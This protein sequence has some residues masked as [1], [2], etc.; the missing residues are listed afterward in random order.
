MLIALQN[1]ATL[2]EASRSLSK[3]ET[4][5]CP[6][7]KSPVH[8]KVGAVMRPHFAH[9]QNRACQVFS[10]GET[11]EHIQGKMHLKEWLESQDI[12]VELEAYLPEL[13]QRPDLLVTYHGQ[14]I[15]IEFQCSSLSIHKVTERTAGYLKN[16]YRVIWILGE[17]FTYKNQL[18]AFQK[19]CLTH[20][21]ENLVLFHYS[22]TKK[23]LEY[24]YN[25]TLKQN[26][27]M[28]H[29]KKS[30][31][32]GQALNFRLD[33]KKRADLKPL[34]VEMEHMKML[35]QLTASPSYGKAFLQLLYDEKDTLVSM[36][37]EV[38]EVVPHEWLLYSNAYEWKM[39]MIYWLEEKSL[40][41]V[42][43]EKQLKAFMKTISYYTIPQASTVQRLAP[44]FEFI[45]ILTQADVL[46]QIRFDK[47]VL[48]N[49]PKHYRYLEDKFK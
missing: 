9:Y 3:E 6:S 7:C 49:Y 48:I 33:K 28:D 39:Q 1:N 2:I 5:Q 12:E 4:Y 31:H 43:T 32:F 15:A 37:K 24:R 45:D 34:D 35:R 21:E 16:G 41:T 20:L 11:A 36:P 27:K 40:R 19:S 44:I 42:I 29:Y 17:N 8:L 18:T 23:R 38:Y 10:E 22:V 47:W 26:K 25:F 46:K 13:Q 30:I 14:K